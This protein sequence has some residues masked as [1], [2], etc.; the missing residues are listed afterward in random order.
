VSSVPSQNQPSDF[1]ISIALV[2]AGGAIGTLLRY[3]LSEATPNT[4]LSL[5]VVNLVG[6]LALGFINSNSWFATPARRNFWGVG[7]CGGFTTMSGI[8]L[9]P[10]EQF[11]LNNIWPAFIGF[12]ALGGVLFYW[13]GK[14]LG[15][16]FSR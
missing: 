5:S 15:D 12:S 16:R 8:S 7:F 1:R 10:L 2:F 3:A 9:L 4:F 6:S 13:I 14:F 11:G